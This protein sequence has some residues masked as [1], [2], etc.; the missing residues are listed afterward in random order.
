MIDKIRNTNREYRLENIRILKS[1]KQLFIDK[2]ELID[3]W[4]ALNEE[5]IE[6]NLQMGLKKYNQ[7]L[8]DWM[9]NYSITNYGEDYK[10]CVDLTYSMDV[11]THNYCK[12]WVSRLVNHIRSKGY[13]VDGFMVT[14]KSLTNTLHNHILM[15]GNFSANVG[16]NIITNYWKKIGRVLVREYESDGGYNIYISKF[17][18]GS[19]ENQFELL[20]QL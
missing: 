11:Y 16:K 18:N 1:E 13:F 3:K 17:I 7:D 19:K 15:Y 2:I 4:I 14:E 10:L 12:K 20:S 6:N 5:L 9:G 8:S